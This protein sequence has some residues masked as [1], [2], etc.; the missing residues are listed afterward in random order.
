[1][2]APMGVVVDVDVFDKTG[3]GG[4]RVGNGNGNGNVF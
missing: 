2:Y 4:E 3:K 1:M